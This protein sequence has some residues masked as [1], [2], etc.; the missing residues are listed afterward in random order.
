[1]GAT[2]TGK[3][4]N[5]KSGFASNCAFGIVEIVRPPV[6]GVSVIFSSEVVSSISADSGWGV[7]VG[8]TWS[9]GSKYWLVGV[10]S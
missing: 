1:M 6:L 9:A 10:D 7:L 5:S 2:Y 8:V 4:E 3:V